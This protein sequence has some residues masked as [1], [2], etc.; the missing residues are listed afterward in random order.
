[1][2]RVAAIGAVAVLIAVTG[3]SSSTSDSNSDGPPD[4]EEPGASEAASNVAIIAFGMSPSDEQNAQAQ[5]FLD[6]AI[7][8]C[9]DLST[10]EDAADLYAGAAQVSEDR[11]ANADASEILTALEDVFT[12]DTTGQTC[13]DLATAYVAILTR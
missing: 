11:R 9:P 12:T 8:S 13:T 4:T 7:A 5:T 2:I 10:K 3:C 1:M 6:R